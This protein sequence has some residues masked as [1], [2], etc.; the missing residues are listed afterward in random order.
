MVSF[1]ACHK[2]SSGSVSS[3]I[4]EAFVTKVSEVEAKFH[5]RRSFV[6]QSLNSKL[7]SV[8]RYHRLR[9]G[10]GVADGVRG[11]KKEECPMGA[12]RVETRNPTDVLDGMGEEEEVAGGDEER[13]E[14]T[15]ASFL[16]QGKVLAVGNSQG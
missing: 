11:Y 6:C 13:K 5:R 1:L 16:S 15:D 3:P 4:L 7:S 10:T 12:H 9:E 8:R 2:V 14:G